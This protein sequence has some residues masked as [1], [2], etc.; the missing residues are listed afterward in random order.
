MTDPNPAVDT[1]FPFKRVIPAFIVAAVYSILY[2]YFQRIVQPLVTPICS[3]TLI[4]T[5]FD[6]SHRVIR[7]LQRFSAQIDAANA[8]IADLFESEPGDGHDEV[9]H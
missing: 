7:E 2:H 4:F 6:C 3:V 8:R 1:K 9:V 5:M